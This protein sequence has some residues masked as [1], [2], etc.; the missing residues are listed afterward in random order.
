M[1]SNQRGGAFMKVVI[2]V[3]LSLAGLY[4]TT[5]AQTPLSQLDAHHYRYESNPIYRAVVDSIE[6]IYFRYMTSEPEYRRQS[7]LKIPVVVH[8]MHLPEDQMPLDGTSNPTDAQIRRGLDWVNMAFGNRGLFSGG[9]E[10]TNAGDPQNVRAD[11]LP[12]LDLNVDTQIEFILAKSDPQKNPTTG[13]LRT[14]TTLSNL[15]YLDT[16]AG[17]NSTQERCLK[18]LSRWNTADYF[19]IWLVNSVCKNKGENCDEDGFA[20]PEGIRQNAPNL[21]GLVLEV[22]RWGV[23]PNLTTRAV[24]NIGHYLS[25][26]DTY[27]QTSG[28]DGCGTSQD[29]SCFS[30]GDKICDT[31]PD[32]FPGGGDCTGGLTINSCYTDSILPG[33]PYIRDVEDIYENYMDGTSPGQYVC[34][35][36]FTKDQKK[37]MRLS[38]ALRGGF[39]NSPGIKEFFT[40]MSIVRVRQPQLVVCGSSLV[41]QVILRNNGNRE[42][43]S[44]SLSLMVDGNDVSDI[45]W[46]GLLLPG[47]TFELVGSPI[48]GLSPTPHRFRVE[49]LSVNQDQGDIYPADNAWEQPFTMVDVSK[50]VTDFEYCEDMEYGIIPIKWTTSNLDGKIGFDIVEGTGCDPSSNRFAIRYGSGD[51]FMQGQTAAPFGTKDLLISPILD[52]VDLPNAVLTFDYAHQFLGDEQSMDLRVLVLPDCDARIREIWGKSGAALETISAV[53]G[54]AVPGWRPINCGDWDQAVINLDPYT[55]QR[56]RL[57]FEI[58]LNGPYSQNFYIDNICISEQEPCEIPT[59]IPTQQGVYQADF[60]SCTDSA[61]WTHFIKSAGSAPISSEDLLL[62]SVRQPDGQPPILAAEDVTLYV[63]GKYGQNG[64][65]L[66][67]DAPY[68]ENVQGWHTMGRYLKLRPP[69]QPDDSVEIKFY[70]DDQDF[71][72]MQTAIEPNT[73]DGYE[74]LVFYNINRETEA[75]PTFL[76]VDVTSNS[77]QEIPHAQFA[78]P[79]AQSWTEE[80]FEQYRAATFKVDNLYGIGGGTDGLGLAYGARYPVSLKGGLAASQ[81]GTDIVLQ[82]ETPREKRSQAFEVYHSRDTVNFEMISEIGAKGRSENSSRYQ[83]PHNVISKG[84]HWYY[85]KMRHQDGVEVLTDTIEVDFDPSRIVDV[86]PNP[87]TSEIKIQLDVPAGTLVDFGIYNGNWDRMSQYYWEHD[88][89]RVNC[90]DLSKL[91]SGIFF[92]VV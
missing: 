2:A 75:N 7:V 53:S 43:T 10:F 38:V 37:R 26:F 82:W 35:N 85:V 36:S 74:R 16:C 15:A 25:L 30:Q 86:Y 92:Y 81:Q 48:L 89:T 20:L 72:D 45:D 40:D 56:V 49:I 31:P 54:P 5:Y 88:P 57:I 6:Q 66:S 91:P 65:D 23:D 73:L 68:V 80:V 13:I 71:Q 21:D 18:S 39:Q 55:G 41:P 19:N 1:R 27:L 61:G 78:D 17:G 29:S 32:A 76:H 22:S 60:A 79:N 63:T 42:I 59:A 11:S 8:I 87:T 33:S 67:Q 50:Q 70:Y 46:E 14:P 9:P 3:L 58:K 47:D 64:H 83:L 69:V 52:L 51:A 12:F 24:H 90:L 28:M 34:K 62:F 44:C 84:A 77:F 4:T